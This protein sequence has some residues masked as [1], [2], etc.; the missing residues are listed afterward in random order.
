MLSLCPSV[1]YIHEPFNIHHRPGIC[2]S[3]FVHWFTY[4]C[5]ENESDYVSGLAD[6]LQFK[7]QL[8][9]EL[10]A[11]RSPKDVGRMAR[12]VALFTRNRLLKKRPLL[13]DPIA[14]FSAEWLARRFNMEVVVLIRHPAAFAGSLKKAQWTHPFDHFLQQPLLMERHLSDYREQIEAYARTEHDYVN[15]AILLW[16]LIHH[17]IIQYR[18]RHPNWIFAT[19]ESLSGRPAEEFE[20]LYNRLGLS[21]SPKVRDAICRT[22]SVDPQK[23]IAGDFKRDSQANIWEWKNRLTRDE[24]RRVKEQTHTIS[25]EFYGE[26][27]WG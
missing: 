21:Y 8:F 17:M 15:Q 19:H 4:V 2:R 12:D 7:Y 14:V 13:K 6:C 20:A 27:D 25:K 26:E 22:T 18:A 11:L 10:K 23:E 24:I 9:D 1:A 3:T 5:E 16:N